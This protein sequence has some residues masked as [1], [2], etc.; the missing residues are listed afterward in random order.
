MDLQ[1][2]RTREMAN[3]LRS[4]LA[5]VGPH[6]RCLTDLRC[7]RTCA[8]TRFRTLPRRKYTKPVDSDVIEPLLH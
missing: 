4:T 5:I 3:V 8:M 6:A 1:R 7:G 2:V